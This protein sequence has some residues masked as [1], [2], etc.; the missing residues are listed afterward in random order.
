MDSLF[1]FVFSIIVGL[2]L[3]I[4]RKHK[5]RVIVSAALLVVLI[6]IDH[7]FGMTARGTFHNIFFVSAIPLILFYIGYMYEKPYHSIK[8][9]TYSLLLG[10]M[11]IAHVICDMFIDGS[12]KLLYPFNMTDF[13]MPDIWILA[14]PDFFSPIVSPTGIAL[15]IILLFIMIAF[16]VEEFI[17]NLE[18]NKEKLSIAV[19]DTN[20]DVF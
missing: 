18:K 3:N 10:L 11:L 15:G 13:T 17:Y 14:T 7:F 6:D 16:Y 4:R 9:Q 1:H 2:S 12:V 19:R 20:E 5:L 8:L